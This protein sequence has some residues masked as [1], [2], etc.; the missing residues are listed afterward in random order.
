MCLFKIEKKRFFVFTNILTLVPSTLFLWLV[1]PQTYYPNTSFWIILST[2][3][4]TV[5]NLWMTAL[6]EPGII[7]RNPKHEI[8]SFI[9]LL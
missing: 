9:I 3:V 2:L 7:P 8:V 5:W 6:V 4:L 1:I